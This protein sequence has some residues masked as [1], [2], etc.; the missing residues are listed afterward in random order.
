M[1]EIRDY[2]KNELNLK[3]DQVD[4][5]AKN[6]SKY[7]DIFNEFCAWLKQRNFDFENPVKVEGYTAKRISELAPF[8]SGVGVYNFLISFREDPERAKFYIS[9]GFPRL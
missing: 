3:E 7:D 1:D 6:I 2:L 4:R 9:E 8:M 5:Y